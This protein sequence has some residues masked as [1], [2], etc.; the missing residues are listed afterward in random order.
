MLQVKKKKLYKIIIIW[1]IIDLMNFDTCIDA[2]LLLLFSL[3]F[4]ITVLNSAF[5][6]YFLK[7]KSRSKITKFTE[8]NGIKKLS[9]NRQK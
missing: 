6:E 7:K 4:N 5:F 3:H 1:A 9:C 2:Q 8:V